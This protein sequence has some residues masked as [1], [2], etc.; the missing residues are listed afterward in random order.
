M[1]TV[2]LLGEIAENYQAEWSLDVQTPAEALRAINANRPG[3][4]SA[5]DQQD[6]VVILVDAENP[7]ESKQITD[8]NGL[9]G[10]QDEVLYIV[11]KI[12]GEFGAAIVGA[13]VSTAFAETVAGVIIST[14]IDI[15]ISIA[16][17][18]VAQMISGTPDGFGANNIEQP[19]NKPS[20]IF[21]GVVNTDRQG[22]RV[23]VLYGGPMLVGSMVLSSR[24]NTKDI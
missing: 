17:S 11:P 13:V 4:L 18:T 6:Y 7:E 9:E 2:K 14:I 1:K 3:F 15:A 8:L 5:C 20:Y 19:E 10:W 12:E 21:N 24:V 23:P 16:I 22:H